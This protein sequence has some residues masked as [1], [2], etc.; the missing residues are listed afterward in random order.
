VWSLLATDYF[1][2]STGYEDGLSTNHP[3]QFRACFQNAFACLLAKTGGGF[4]TPRSRFSS[5]YAPSSRLALACFN[6]HKQTKP[7]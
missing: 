1:V 4:V 5:Q 3:A 6:W 2:P 7:F